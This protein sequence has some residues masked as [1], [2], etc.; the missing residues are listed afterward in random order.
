MFRQASIKDG[1]RGGGRGWS[2]RETAPGWRIGR[3][4]AAERGWSKRETAPGWPAPGR[5]GA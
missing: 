3:H 5:V 1:I 2:K 4:R